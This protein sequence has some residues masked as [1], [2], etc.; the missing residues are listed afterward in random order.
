MATEDSVSMMQNIV[1]LT[2]K[3]TGL[4]TE[5]AKRKN[6]EED[7]VAKL[8]DSAEMRENVELKEVIRYNNMICI[9]LFVMFC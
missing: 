9:Y 1:K 6:I 4:E 8:A 5:L 3:I 2:E 7:L